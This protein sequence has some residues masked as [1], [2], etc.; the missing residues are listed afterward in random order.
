MKF[1]RSQVHKKKLSSQ[2]KISVSALLALIFLFFWVSW[3]GGTPVNL[4]KTL[5]IPK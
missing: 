5:I 2:I 1:E 3:T 4:G